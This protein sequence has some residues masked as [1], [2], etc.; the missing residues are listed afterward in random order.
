VLYRCCD[1]PRVGRANLN[2]PDKKN[3]DTK[4]W[5]RLRQEVEVE[6]DDGG[7]GGTG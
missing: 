5:S 1:G 3:N 4:E 6:D 2:P 7:A